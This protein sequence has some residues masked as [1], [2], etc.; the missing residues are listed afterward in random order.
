MAPATMASPATVGPVRTRNTLSV[1]LTGAPPHRHGPRRRAPTTRRAQG[2]A[3]SSAIDSGTSPTRTRRYGAYA[4]VSPVPSR[5]GSQYA[6]PRLS[7]V[8]AERC[9][10][11]ATGPYPSRVAVGSTVHRLGSHHAGCLTA[12]RFSVACRASRSFWLFP[13]IDYGQDTHPPRL[14]GAAWPAGAPAAAT[15]QDNRKEPLTCLKTMSDY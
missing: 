6:L 8:R 13:F 11:A 5:T 4:S 2:P 14:G 9:S 7:G 1:W 3:S 10:P 15:S 12:Q